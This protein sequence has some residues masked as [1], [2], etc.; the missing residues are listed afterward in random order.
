MKGLSLFLSI[1]GFFAVL[2]AIVNDFYQIKLFY[3]V[4][5]EQ[6]CFIKDVLIVEKYFNVDGEPTDL[7]HIEG[8]LK[9]NKIKKTITGYMPSLDKDKN[10]NYLVWYCNQ[11]GRN[12]ILKRKKNEKSPSIVLGG[13][14]FNLTLIILFIPS[15]LYYIGLKILEKN[16]K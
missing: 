8:Y 14:W 13:V 6:S 3:V 7:Y 9:R 1:L 12:F 2:S 16:K 10:G 15:L 4:N 11:E 5:F